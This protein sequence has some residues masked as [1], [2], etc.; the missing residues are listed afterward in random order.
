MDKI[1]I[2]SLVIAVPN[3]NGEEKLKNLD[4]PSEG[5]TLQQYDNLGIPPPKH[6]LEKEDGVFLEDDDLEFGE[7]DIAFKIKD[8]YSWE[9]DMEL[10]SNVKLSNGDVHHV[11]QSFEEI[12]DYIAY[13]EFTKL[14]KWIFKIKNKLKTIKKKKN[15]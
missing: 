11:W 8:I 4:K 6:L 13:M 14:Q 10:G 7:L 5:L 15:D 3:E 1:I 2:L 9:E 12:A